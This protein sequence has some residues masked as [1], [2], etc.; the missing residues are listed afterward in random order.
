MGRHRGGEVGEDL[1]GGAD[2]RR[3]SYRRGFLTVDGWEWTQRRVG[4]AGADERIEDLDDDVL[5]CRGVDRDAFQGVDPGEADAARLSGSLRSFTASTCNSR[6]WVSRFARRVS[7]LAWPVSSSAIR[8]P[9]TAV[10]AAAAVSSPPGNA[11]RARIAPSCSPGTSD[12]ADARF[13]APPPL[14]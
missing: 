9:A 11:A 1:D 3:R 8:P 4:A 13:P 14:R 2:V 12:P 7:A 5:I 6:T 10:N